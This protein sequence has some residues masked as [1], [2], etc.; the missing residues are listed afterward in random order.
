MRFFFKT[1]LHDHASTFTLY[2]TEQVRNLKLQNNDQRYIIPIIKAKWKLNNAQIIEIP[3][4]HQPRKHGK[5]HYSVTKNILFGLY[6]TLK[7][8][9]Q[10]SKEY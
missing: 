9:I 10:L 5:S 6:E 8:K 2:R 7:K 3:I 1:Q 4:Q